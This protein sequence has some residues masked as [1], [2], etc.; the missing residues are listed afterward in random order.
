MPLSSIDD[1]SST[2]YT[3]DESSYYETE[4]SYY[5]DYVPGS[6]YID[7]TRQYN[8]DESL[9]SFDS[10][11]EAAQ[12]PSQES[13][14]SPKGPIAQ[15]TL[16]GPSLSRWRQQL[17]ALSK[18]AHWLDGTNTQVFMDFYSTK[19]NRWIKASLHAVG[20]PNTSLSGLIKVAFD[21][22]S[23]RHHVKLRIDSDLIAPLGTHT[24]IEE[25]SLSNLSA[26]TISGPY[27]RRAKST[28]VWCCSA[29]HKKLNQLENSAHWNLAA[30]AYSVM[31]PYYRD[32]EFVEFCEEC[33]QIH[34]TREDEEK[35]ESYYGYLTES[36][37]SHA[38]STYSAESVQ[39]DS[40]DQDET[41]AVS[42]SSPVYHANITGTYDGVYGSADIVKQSNEG[43]LSKWVIDKNQCLI[44][45]IY[46]V[47]VCF[48]VYIYNCPQPD[49]C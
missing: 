19:M 24:G 12:P 43:L 13:N 20:N 30:N 41:E 49:R 17:M 26:R 2:S 48:A 16:N 29:C 31:F 11:A 14:L 7:N 28:D 40:D 22:P 10:W 39:I 3:G 8:D 47:F 21:T 25:I 6:S 37:S 4:S 15:L 44:Y 38:E 27:F 32:S 36:S 45:A 1:E 5:T 18:N 33:I 46:V 9:I 42:Y 35:D 34:K 23:G